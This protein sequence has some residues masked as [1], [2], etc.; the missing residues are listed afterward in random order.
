MQC[1]VCGQAE[2]VHDTR[3]LPYTHKGETTTIAAVEA[4]FCPACNES[5][6]CMAETDRVMCAMQAFNRQ[7]Q[8]VGRAS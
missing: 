1:P 3:D 7:V 5:V 8:G 4:D 2:L 6:T